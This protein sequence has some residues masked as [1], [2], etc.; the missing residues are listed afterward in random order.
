MRCHDPVFV[1]GHDRLSPNHGLLSSN[2]LL[3]NMFPKNN[4]RLRFSYL[5][6]ISNYRKKYLKLKENQHGQ[7]NLMDNIS[8]IVETYSWNY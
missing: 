4:G 2:K 5:K 3:R 8:I 1:K 7:L 6:I